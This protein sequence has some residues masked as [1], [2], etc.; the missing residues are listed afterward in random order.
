MQ[1]GAKRF[2]KCPRPN[3]DSAPPHARAVAESLGIGKEETGKNTS[4][5]SH[6][7][8]P[9]AFQ[10][11]FFCAKGMW[12]TVFDPKFSGI[13][14]T[15]EQRKWVV[16]WKRTSDSERTFEVKDFTKRTLSE[17]KNGLSHQII[18]NLEQ[19]AAT[20][21]KETKEKFHELCLKTQVAN[22]KK[23]EAFFE[24]AKTLNDSLPRM[25]RSTED[26][27]LLK[28]LLHESGCYGN[29]EL[30]DAPFLHAL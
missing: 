9:T 5:S 8:V 11:R 6:F 20:A 28:M 22:L 13:Y 24:S 4:R 7:Y 16:D 14:L 19:L 18:L 29:F 3:R 26:G 2:L 1:A 30:L 21:S 27:R 17:H 12:V 15:E 25:K 10:G 23:V